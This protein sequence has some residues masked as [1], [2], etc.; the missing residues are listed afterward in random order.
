MYFQGTPDINRVWWTI[1]NLGN[2]LDNSSD[3]EWSYC[4]SP[5]TFPAQNENSKDHRVGD[6]CGKATMR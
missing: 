5:T 1:K 2:S 6:D 3:L 4:E